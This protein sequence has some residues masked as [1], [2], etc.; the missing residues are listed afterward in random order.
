MTL[1]IT[2]DGEFMSHWGTRDFVNRPDNDKAFR[3][4][5]NL[6]GA[7]KNGLK[8]YLFD[9][10]MLPSPVIACGETVFHTDG[11]KRR[12]VL[13]SVV[14]TAWQAQDGSKVLILVNPDKEPHECIVEGKAYAVP[15]LDV[16]SIEL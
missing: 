7:Y 8:K 1:V 14:S 6:T 3:L 4:I 15:P 16:I 11:N 9:G 13:P 10:R 12:I 2:P 5:G